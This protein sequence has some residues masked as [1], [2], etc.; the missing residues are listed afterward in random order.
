MKRSGENE[1]GNSDAIGVEKI[2]DGLSKLWFS[3]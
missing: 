1:T 2:L 3:E